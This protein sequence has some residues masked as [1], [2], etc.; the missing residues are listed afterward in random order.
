MSTEAK[1]IRTVL[2]K[3]AREE[4][5]RD[6]SRTVEAEHVLIALAGMDRGVAAEILAG[7]GL[8]QDAIR[9]A[10]DRE[11]EQS[12]AAAGIAVQVDSLPTATPDH[13]R[14]PQI[15]ESSRLLLKRAIDAPPKASGTRIGPVRVLV[16]L[17]GTDHGRVARALEIAGVDRLALHARAAEALAQGN[18]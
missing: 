3:T 12:L 4:A 8:T 16:S 7:A 1:D 2:V 11:W 13:G 17:L 14:S 10:L 5:R 6:G 15:G 9:A 18:R